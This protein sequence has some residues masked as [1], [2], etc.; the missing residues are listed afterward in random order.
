MNK[1]KTVFGVG[2]IYII[3]LG[4]FNLL[5]FTIFKVHTSV[6]WVSYAF[7]TVAFL[8]QLASM[9]LSFKEIDVETVFFGIPLASFSVYYLCVALVAGTIFMIF[10]KAGFTLAIVIQILILAAFLIIAIISLLSREAVREMDHQLKD[11]VTNH[12]SVLVDVEMLVETSTDPE[13]KVAILKL[14][15]TIRYSDP[16]STPEVEVVEQR[17]MRKISELRINID[18]NQIKDAI[19]GCN[20]IELLY[21]ERNKK[22]VLSK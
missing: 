11:K 2:L 20:E 19:N 1:N 21:L 16:I 22:L 3:L 15:D 10:Q 7:M 5:A 17:I 9:Y 4:V 8:V 18:N 12:K 14:A 6:F 13:L